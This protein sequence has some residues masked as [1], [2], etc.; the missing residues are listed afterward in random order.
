MER[1]AQHRSLTFRTGKIVGAE[2]SRIIDCAILGISAA[3]ARIF[4]SDPTQVPKIFL[5]KVDC[6]DAVHVCER[7]WTDG[8]QIG[9]SCHCTAG[10]LAQGE[11]RTD[12]RTCR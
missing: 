10:A 9:L 8:N 7:V 5:L 1:H 11:P 12:S 4:V 3:G 6:S 2:E